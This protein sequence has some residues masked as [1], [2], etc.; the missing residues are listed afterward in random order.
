MVDCRAFS[1]LSEARDVPM[2]TT[3]LAMPVKGDILIYRLKMQP[4]LT[5]FQLMIM[6]QEAVNNENRVTQLLQ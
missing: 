4:I 2:K 5:A 1:F 3:N 6:D